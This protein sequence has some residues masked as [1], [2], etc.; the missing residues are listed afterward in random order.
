MKR[1]MARGA[2]LAAGMGLGAVAARAAYAALTR[3][4]PGLNGL[5]GED[6]W[7]RVNHRGEPV[8][9]LEGPAVVAGAAAAGLL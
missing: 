9:L 7:G 5:P 3:R 8:T 2:R 1:G 4:P 6:V